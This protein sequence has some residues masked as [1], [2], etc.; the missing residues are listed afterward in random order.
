MNKE[1]VDEILT[2]IEYTFAKSMPKIPHWY[3]LEKKWTDKELYQKVVDFI[4]ANG[5]QKRFFNRVYTYYNV[6]EYKYWAMKINDGSGII[7]R[8]L[9]ENE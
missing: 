4:N 2:S 5:Y 9:I 1:T 3:T 6:G 8:T 7:N